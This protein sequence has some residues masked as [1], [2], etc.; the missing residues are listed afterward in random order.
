MEESEKT[1][2]K[3]PNPSPEL[4]GHCTSLLPLPLAFSFIPEL[5]FPSRIRLL[6]LNATRILDYKGL[7]QSY[8]LSNT[9]SWSQQKRHRAG[10]LAEVERE[11]EEGW[12]EG[13]AGSV[14]FSMKAGGGACADLHKKSTSPHHWLAGER[15]GVG[16]AWAQP[17]VRSW[18]SEPRPYLGPAP[19][20]A[21]ARGS[22]SC[23]WRATRQMR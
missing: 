2:S 21:R 5:L 19:F 9:R 18:W 3:G 6:A 23:K 7:F 10:N 4:A 13:R 11:R 14:L 8:Y 16:A 15:G 22:A 1:L 17:A 12:R 20:S